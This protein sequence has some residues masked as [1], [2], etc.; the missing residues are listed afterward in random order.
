MQKPPGHGADLVEELER[1]DRL[2]V[3]DGSCRH[4]ELQVAVDLFG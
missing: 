1:V 2:L 4:E 3:T